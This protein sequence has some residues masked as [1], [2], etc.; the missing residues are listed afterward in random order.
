[1]YPQAG[2]QQHLDGD[3]HQQPFVGLGG[4]EQLRGGGVVEGL[5]QWVVAAG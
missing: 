4:A 3:P 2:A 5:G 1:V